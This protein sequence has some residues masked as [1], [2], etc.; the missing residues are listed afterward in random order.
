MPFYIRDSV[1]VGPFR[2]NL[3]RSGLGISAGVKGFR[4]GTGP[5]GHYVHAGRGGLYYRSSLGSGKATGNRPTPSSSHEERAGPREKFVPSADPAIEMR[6]VSSADVQQMRDA[7]FSDIL[8]D[9]NRTKSQ[10]PLTVW[11]VLIAVIFAIALGMALGPFGF[12]LGIIPIAFGWV[13]GQHLD[14]NRR[15]SVLMYD[16]D[17]QAKGAFERLTSAFDAL[18]ACHGKWHVDAGGKVTDLHS[19][20]RNAGAAHIVDKRPTSFEYGMPNLIESNVVPP[21]IKS[22]KETLY[23]LPDFLLVVHGQ[24]VGAVAYDELIFSFQDTPF[25]EEEKPPPDTEIISYVWKYPNKSGGPDRRFND[26]R[27]LP[28]CMYESF[29][30]M[31]GN[32]LNELLQVSKAGLSAPFKSA[33]EELAQANGSAANTE[34]LPMLTG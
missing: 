17:A 21:S 29:H 6:A 14:R 1:S 3:S 7:R 20:K 30:L 13:L 12:F 27:E 25:I 8:D 18:A 31:S 23:F 22:G 9:I 33:I 5:R 11:T 32:G 4:V 10:E 16:L 24:K 26:N 19:W 34:S 2:F 28:V 15:T